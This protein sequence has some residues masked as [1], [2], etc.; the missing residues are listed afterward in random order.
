MKFTNLSGT[1]VSLALKQAEEKLR[2]GED[3]FPEDTDNVR[4]EEFIDEPLFTAFEKAFPDSGFQFRQILEMSDD[5]I[6]L[7]DKNQNTVFANKKLCEILGISSS[8]IRKHNIHAFLNDEAKLRLCDAINNTSPKVQKLTIRLSTGN[9]KLIWAAFTISAILDRENNYQGSLVLVS[10][11]TQKFALEK[12]LDNATN[13]ARIGG[14]DIDLVAGSTYWSPMTKEIHEVAENYQPD[15][16]KGFEFYKEAHHRNKIS[17]AVALAIESGTPWDLELLIV[18]AKGNECWIR[19]IGEAEFSEGKCVRLTGSFQ[20]INSTKKAQLEVLQIATEKNLILE[21]IGD[22]FFAV[23]KNWTVTYWNKEAER[24]LGMPRQDVVGKILWD[25]F[26]DTVDSTFHYHYHKAIE[27]NTVQHFEACYEKLN[28]WIEVSAY[29][30][31]DGLSV[32]FKDISERK[33]AEEERAALMSQIM[34]RN[35]DLEQFSYM[36][37]HNLRAPVANIIGL[38]EELDYEG[39]TTEVKKV[40]T[41][42]MLV[43][44]SRLDEVIF[45]LNSILQLKKDQPDMHETIDFASLTQGISNEI[46]TLIQQ[47]DV[48]IKTNFEVGSINSIKSYLHSIF[49]NLI[50]NSIKYRRDDVNPIIHISSQI[51][52]NGLTLV[53]SDNGIGIDL[54]TKADQ[55]F[56]LYKRFHNHV[57]G[58]GL[59]LFMVKTQVEI[60]GG[61]I[62]VHSEIDK[63]TEFRI[64]FTK[65]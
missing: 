20:D 2:V 43:S 58:K 39:H 22:S 18:T 37:S 50:V 54:E 12:L 30:L 1:D 28:V 63:G 44:V 29:P 21:S 59:G 65:L 46:S 40:L 48:T 8:D 16:K 41:N 33:R 24:F 42:D 6:W 3:K 51:S 31:P 23:D 25:V 11:M 38:A 47:Q 15:Y 34:R 27:E 10:D 45:D 64:Q 9:N 53:F 56:G 35:K 60:L 13:M 62:S 17:E 14:F 55:V 61:T 26:P 36:V 19:T 57:D 4:H 7:L 49:Y 32:Y 52:E 5:G